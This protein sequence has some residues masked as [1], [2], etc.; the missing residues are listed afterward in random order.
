M[1]VAFLGFAEYFADEV[2]GSLYFVDVTRLVALDDQDS[3]HYAGSGGNVQEE[4]FPVSGAVR[5]GGEVWKSLGSWNAL[6]AS[7]FHS[8]LSNFRRSLKKGRPL[9]PSR[10]MN[11]LKAAMHPMSFIKSFLLLGDP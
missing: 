11:L 3:I 2:D 6:E 10:L 5:M 8:N 4:D 9:S 1:R 7:S